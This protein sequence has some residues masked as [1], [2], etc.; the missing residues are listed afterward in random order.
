MCEDLTPNFGNKRTRCRIITHRFAFPLSTGISFFFL[1]NMTVVPHQTHF[2]VS[3]IEDK[4]ENLIW[5]NYGDQGSA[6]H[7][8]RTRLPGCN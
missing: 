8:H 2:S 6:E 1:N 3:R 4:T 5:H 7:P